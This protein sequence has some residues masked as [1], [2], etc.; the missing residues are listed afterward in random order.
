MVMCRIYLTDRDLEKLTKKPKK[1][2]AWLSEKMSK[3]SKEVTWTKLSLEQKK[4]Y[5]VAQAVELSNILSSQAVRELAE[6]EGLNPQLVMKMRWVLPVKPG[7][8]AKARL[9]VLGYQAHNLTQVET[10]SPT[11]SRSG[12]QR[13]RTLDSS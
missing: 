5:D 9:V 3:K 8:T 13:R 2:A 6:L 12:W 4:E 7:G 10:A 11:F 1:A